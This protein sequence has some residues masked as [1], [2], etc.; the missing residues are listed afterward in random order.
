MDATKRRAE[1]PI[2]I[3]WRRRQKRRE[4]EWR[5]FAL[6]IRLLKQKW[7]DDKENIHHS[8][9]VLY[10]ADSPSVSVIFSPVPSDGDC[11]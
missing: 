5:E 7:N 1:D 2:G 6:E 8:L 11:L 3:E 9:R 10:S 4:D